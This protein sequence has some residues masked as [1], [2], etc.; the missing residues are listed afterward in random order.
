VANIVCIAYTVIV[1]LVCVAFGFVAVLVCAAFLLVTAVICVVWFILVELFCVLWI[2]VLSPVSWF[3]WS[4][5]NGAA[6]FQ[7]TDGTIFLNEGSSD[8]RGTRSWWKLTPNND[9]SY[10]DGSWSKAADSINARTYFSSAVLADGRL[11]VF[12]GEF[13]DESGSNSGDDE[14]ESI[15]CEIY[16]PVADSWQSIAAPAGWA[17]IGDGACSVMPGGR[18]YLG[19]IEN[20]QT[21]LFDPATL[22]WTAMSKK[23]DRS[24]EETWVLLP[25]GSVIVAQCANHPSSERY[26]IATDTWQIEP[27]LPNDLVEASSIEIGPGVLMPDGRTF[28]VGATGATAIYTM[29]TGGA[30]QGTWT[31]GPNINDKLDKGSKDGPGCLMVNG[32]VLFPVA[33]IDGKKDSYLSPCTFLEFDGTDIIPSTDAP[34]SD[35]PTFAGRLMILPTGEIMWCRQDDS[36]MY[37]F[38]YK[39]DPDGTW[40]P[41]ITSCP[42]TVTPNTTIPISGRQFNGLSQCVGYGDDFSAATN[43][44]LVRIRNKKSGHIRYCRTSNHTTTDAAGNTITSMG[45]ATG[46][47]IITTQVEIPSDLELGDSELFVVANGIPSEAFAITVGRG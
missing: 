3:C 4:H 11:V 29:A 27:T 8:G 18:F 9:G 33:P 43:Y 10:I 22:T 26:I 25:D 20:T 40:R 14:D 1:S 32:N 30:T 42:T 37:A 21:A 7:L 12:G 41:V 5:A 44:P 2:I 17:K 13:T 46:A 31:A 6:L 39:G 36:D 35:C 15:L 16:N 24:S 23:G 45:V 28:F 34:N 47:A 19:N 38:Q